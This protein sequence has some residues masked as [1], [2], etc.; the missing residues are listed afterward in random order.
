MD[1]NRLIPCVRSI[2]IAKQQLRN[3]AITIPL[4]VVGFLVL[5]NVFLV[6]S[7]TQTLTIA[8]E[9][10]LAATTA[11]LAPGF[12]LQQ[13]VTDSAVDNPFTGMQLWVN[14]YSD[15]KKWADSHRNYDAYN[16]SLMDKIASQPDVQ[17]YGNWNSDVTR[18]VN[19]RVSTIINAGALPVLVA[20]NIPQRDCGG[21]SSGGSNS[22]QGYE[23]WIRDFAKG[24]GNR[25]SLVIL[26]PD[27]LAM[28]DCLSATDKKV[29]FSLLKDAVNVLNNLGN[30]HVY[31]DAGHSS[32]K[33]V[34]EMS[35]LLKQ[36]GV[37]AAQGFAL[38]VSNFQTNA[39]IITYGAA[40]S[41]KV[42]GKHFVFDTGRNG[43]GPT[44]DNEWCNPWGRALGSKPTTK[45]GHALV[46]A[47][48]WVRGPS[49]SDGACNGGPP[50]GHFW[51]EYG[52]HLAKNTAW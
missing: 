19:D 45:T 35:S 25:K 30:T 1:S 17:W 50:A 42:G 6:G 3:A 10:Q 36:S 28:S 52:L 13:V 23:Q 11:D 49:G 7:K 33:N 16:A 29:R 38:N 34:D 27:A 40:I 20:Y 18:D 43:N 5:I 4:V 48:L 9:P 26:E 46:D 41:K 2:A 21:H 14:P 44:P 51:P 37:A 22:A 31:I 12:G 15:A 32:W 39:S 8:Y 24:I 47:Y